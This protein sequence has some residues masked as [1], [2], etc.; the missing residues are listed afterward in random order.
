MKKTFTTTLLLY[1]IIATHAL[2]SQK[3]EIKYGK[4]TEE[5][6]KMT[7]CAFYPEATS[8]I[9]GESGVL[10]FLYN[11]DKGWQYS[12][13]VTVRKKIFKKTDKDI[14]NIKI[15]TYFPIDRQD[16][17]EIVGLKATTYNL[18][19]GAVVKTKLT[20]SEEYGTRLS[21]YYYETSF[22]MPDVQEGSVIEYKYTIISD[23]INNLSTWHYQN[24]IPTAYS[25]FEYTIPEFFHYQIAQLGNFYALEMYDENIQESFTY[26]WTNYGPMGNNQSGTS[27]IPS[28]SKRKTTIARNIV[29]FDFEPYMNNKSDWPTRMEFQLATIEMPN[30]PIKNIAQDYNSFSKQLMERESFGL[31]LD[32]GGFAKDFIDSQNGKSEIEKALAIYAWI[33]NTISWNE[34]YRFT[35]QDANRTSLKDKTG[36][37]ADINIALLAALREAG[38]YAYPVLLSTRGH[39]ALHPV[40]PNMADFNYVI[41]QVKI[42]EK[43]YLVDAT[44]K[45]PFGMLPT[46]CFNGNGWLVSKNGG[47]WVNLKNSTHLSAS[48]AELKFSENEMR[49]SFYKKY[50]AHAAA[51]IHNR[52]IENGIE[53][54]QSQLAEGFDEGNIEN[55]AYADSNR[56]NRIEISY[57][58][59]KDFAG[60]DI[61]YVDLMKY[62]VVSE[63]PFKREERFST[64]DFEYEITKQM[65]F[66]IHIPE[67]YKAELPQTAMLR[68]PNKG[69]SF[70]YSASQIGDKISIMSKMNIKQL[71]F[72]PDEYPG[73]K[74]F[75]QL[76]ADKHNEMVILK[77][78]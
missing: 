53:D 77:K 20:N 19:D 1:C 8:M 52:V 65:L 51:S 15:Q 49:C 67:G 48:S 50:E 64:I 36:S 18:I 9:L 78:I 40:Y 32:K 61:I 73:L 23:F 5:E 72:T 44:S 24:S 70:I 26:R 45:L 60:D 39:G 29:P 28:Q 43:E 75:Y 55:F 63:N 31:Q 27:S 6:L 10:R 30:S 7:E 35:T 56:V 46:R 22:A 58:L 21:D 74:Q 4:I 3:N 62:G 47:E 14:A 54:Y 13:E 66:T 41:V 76:I 2:F 25:Y 71:D 11:N 68:L 42:D 59:V 34:I 12:L 57:D 33:T 16:R 17:E 38:I 69:G 37:V